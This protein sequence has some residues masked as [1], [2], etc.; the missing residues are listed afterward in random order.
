MRLLASLACLAAGAGCVEYD[1]SLT[2]SN[3]SDFE[4]HEMYVTQIDSPQWGPNLLN[5][6]ILFPNESMQ[7]ALDCNTYDAMLVDETGAVCE[8]STIDLCYD[9]ADWIIDNRS[10]EVFEKRAAEKRAA[11]AAAKGQ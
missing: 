7:L 11:D 5:G 9:T 2:V 1:S 8:V 10:C 3:L 4:I 6:D